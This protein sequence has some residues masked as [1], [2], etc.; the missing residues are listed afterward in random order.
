MR[1]SWIA[2]A[3]AACALACAQGCKKDPDRWEKAAASAAASAAPIV[4]ASAPPA[5]S[6]SFNPLFP[7]DG[8]DGYAR[9]FVSEVDGTAQAKLRKD[10]KDVATLTITDTRTNA[11]A[12][13]KFEGA[14]EKVAGHPV[15]AVG[16]NQTT[17]LVADRFQVKVS[18]PTLDH[19]A[20]KAIIEKFDFG[21]LAKL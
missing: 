15:M 6:K 3:L 8:A 12:K 7:P 9:V 2:V 13:K 4:T 20:R 19:D 11:E 10:G 1:A 21:G 17:A 18:S 5:E 16:K 14:T